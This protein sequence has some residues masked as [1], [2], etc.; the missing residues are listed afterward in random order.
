MHSLRLRVPEVPI[1]TPSFPLAVRIGL[2]IASC[3]QRLAERRRNRLTI[4]MLEGLSD[5]M[6]HDIGIDR[7]EITSVVWRRGTDRHP[8]H[9]AA[10][11]S[12]PAR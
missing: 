8:A 11:W 9:P 1:G 12:R 4:R 7:S 3:W 10:T 6:L 5:R 2:A